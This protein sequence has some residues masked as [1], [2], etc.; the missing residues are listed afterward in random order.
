MW[1]QEKYSK[2]KSL[3]ILG[4]EEEQGENIQIKM[5]ETVKKE[6]DVDVIPWKQFTEIFQA[7]SI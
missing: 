1:R 7:L 2:K 4:L 5:I 6:I 3:G